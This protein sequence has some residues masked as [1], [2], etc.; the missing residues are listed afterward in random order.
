MSVLEK[1]EAWNDIGQV[2]NRLKVLEPCTVCDCA[3]DE[4]KAREGGKCMSSAL[5][6]LY[7]SHDVCPTASITADR[8]LA[9]DVMNDKAPLVNDVVA[10]A[11]IETQRD[12]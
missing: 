12:R 7:P 9:A 4:G 3:S 5:K 6:V 10:D 8:N 2:V 1:S 11:C